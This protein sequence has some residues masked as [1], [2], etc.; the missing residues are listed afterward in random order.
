LAVALD[1]FDAAANAR[2]GELLLD[3]GRNEEAQRRL[4]LS[5]LVQPDRPAI[6]LLR[7]RAAARRGAWGRALEDVDLCLADQPND[8]EARWLRAQVRHRSGQYR[9]ALADWDA[10]AFWYTAGPEFHLS[11]AETTRAL[12]QWEEAA[13]EERLGL[14][15]ARKRAGGLSNFA[16]ALVSGP[17]GTRDARRAHMLAHLAVK[18][19]PEDAEV[20][21][22]LAWTEYR[23]G[24]YRQAVATLEQ[25]PAAPSEGQD[26]V[27]LYILAICHHQLGDTAQAR[28]CFQRAES[29]V[30]SQKD[31]GIW[32]SAEISPIRAE[33]EEIFAQRQLQ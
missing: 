25:N 6:R 28:L 1:P 12:G 11:R 18:V 8:V 30:K 2:L 31:W 10:I 13:G 33:A 3:D 21:Q 26:V 16:R 24:R 20:R 15:L 9:E 14:E 27:G 4:S 5:L 32:Q 29:W 23:L 22:T 7:A 17:P 19:R